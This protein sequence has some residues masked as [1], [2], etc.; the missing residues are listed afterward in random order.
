VNDLP[1]HLEHSSVDIFADDTTLSANAHFSDISSL[2]DILNSDLDS[3][4]KWSAQNKMLINT[5]TAKSMVVV[6]KHIPAKLG[7]DAS[8]CLNLKIDSAKISIV[9]SHKLL[10]V[11][12]DSEMSYESYVEELSK[13]IAKCLGLLKHISPYLKKSQREMY[14]NS[15]VKPTIMYGS[16]VWDNSSQNCILRIL[17]LQKRAARFILGVDKKIPSI[18]LFNML[19]WLPFYKESIVKCNTL[20][21]KRINSQY[22]VPEYLR[23]S[24]VRNCDLH[25]RVTRHCG[26]NFVIT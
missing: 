12:L 2:T 25:N 22:C 15:V 14:Y 18:N 24:L 11:T 16:M 3:L 7:S 20:V 6:G 8:Q 5:K 23:S 10:G 19:N 17:K 9:T 21:Y 13:K 4:N 1:L 26:L